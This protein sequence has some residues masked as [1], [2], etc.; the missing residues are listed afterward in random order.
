MILDIWFKA[1]EEQRVRRHAR[2]AIHF[3]AVICGFSVPH[4]RISKLIRR[5]CHLYDGWGKRRDQHVG[6]DGCFERIRHR[7]LVCGF[8]GIARR[9]GTKH[10]KMIC[11]FVRQPGDGNRMRRQKGGILGRFTPIRRRKAVSY[12]RCAWLVR[13]PPNGHA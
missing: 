8:A 3:F 13:I 11:G 4:F 1:R 7:C 5:P 6:N 2:S 9:I 10:L 12:A